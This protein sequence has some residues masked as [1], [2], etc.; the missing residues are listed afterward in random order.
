MTREEQWLLGIEAALSGQS[1]LPAVPNSPAWHYEQM[2]AAIYDVLAGADPARPFPARSWRLD[3]IL[4]SVYCAV[5]GLDDPGCPEPTC[6]IEAFWASVH[7]ALIGQDAARCPSPVWRIEESL[8]KICD[9]SADWGTEETLT[10]AL[11]TFTGKAATRILSLSAALTPQQDLHGYDHPWAGGAGANLLDISTCTTPAAS[12][13]LTKT[14]DADGY[15]HC[16]GINEATGSMQFAVVNVSEAQKAVLAGRG[17]TISITD[18]TGGTIQSSWG[19]RTANE[20]SI[21]ISLQNPGV[22]ATIHL[23]FRIVV[24]T[25]V[26]TV[27]TPY[28]NVCPIGGKTGVSVYVS[29]T[30][31]VGDA[32]EYALDWTSAAGTVYGGT[33]D[34][35]TGELI[36][37]MACISSYAGETIPGPWLSSLDEYA[38]N[39]APTLGAQVVYPLAEPVT[40]QLTPQTPAA[41]TGENNIW[42]NT[43][44]VTVTVKGAAA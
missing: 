7:D 41:L 26:Q 6:R 30:E 31:D 8:R 28:A 35:T 9:A 2:L 19:L 1:P 13:G 15:V 27:F 32:T 38:E 29:P 18:I 25:A 44:N 5:A 36:S 42:S 40:V 23:K 33:A 14:I 37:A 4:W 11:V 12:Y 16:D 39:A 10:G 20:G 3:E 24:S 43:G 34:V 21:A 22:G 17:Y